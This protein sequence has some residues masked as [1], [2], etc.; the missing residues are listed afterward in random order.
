MLPSYHELK[1]PSICGHLGQSVEGGGKRQVFAIGN[2]VNQRLLKPVHDWLMEVLARLPTD[3]TFNQEQ[4]LD[5]LMGERH[6]FSFDLK[7]ATDCWPL[8]IMF[9][10]LQYLFDRSFAS[11]VWLALALNIF[12]V[13]FVGRANS[14]VSFVCG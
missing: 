4:P 12:E 1:K 3:G 6:C 8:Q 2:Y 11:N 5:N 7:F 9:E 13:P 10:V 14:T